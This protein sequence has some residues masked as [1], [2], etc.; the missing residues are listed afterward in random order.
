LRISNRGLAAMF[1]MMNAA[2]LNVALQGLGHADAAHRRALAYAEERVQSRAPVRPQDAQG[3]ADAI[4]LHPAMRRTLLNQRCL[5][6]GARVLAYW[7]AQLLD[8]AESHP[9][10]EVRA[11][12]EGRVS[13]LTPVAK[14]YLTELG[15]RVA[16]EALQVLGGYGYVHEYGA[17]QSVR[18]SRIAMIY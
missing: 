12:A 13:L 8:E 17:E 14:A 6:E 11:A 1:V 5:V 7:T 4:V 2:R 18:D 15:N 9:D 10:A 3:P 16:N